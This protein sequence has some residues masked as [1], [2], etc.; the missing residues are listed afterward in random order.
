MQYKY[1]Q[2]KQKASVKTQINQK[3]Q[4]GDINTLSK[5]LNVGYSTAY[6]KLF[7]SD[8][9]SVMIM[10]EIIKNRESLVKK[11][12][13]K[14]SENNKNNQHHEKSISNKKSA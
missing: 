1:M 11:L 7:R 5:V 9:K 8:K 10:E 3:T 4:T 2:P 14:H 13:K 6:S 12:I